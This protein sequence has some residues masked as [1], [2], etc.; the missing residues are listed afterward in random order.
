MVVSMKPLCFLFLAALLLARPSMAA[1]P[2][3]QPRDEAERMPIASP[4]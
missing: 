4:A 3:P 1:D 2:K